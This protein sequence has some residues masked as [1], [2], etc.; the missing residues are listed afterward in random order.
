MPTNNFNRY[1][2]LICILSLLSFT[3]VACGSLRSSSAVA[4]ANPTP[5]KIAGIEIEPPSDIAAVSA[6]E[7]T[8]GTCKKINS[9]H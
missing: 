1:F 4:V 7:Q 8:L 9:Q 3:T 5:A 2:Q 6:G